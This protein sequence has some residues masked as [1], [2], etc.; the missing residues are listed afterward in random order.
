MTRPHRTWAALRASLALLLGAGVLLGT[1][2]CSSDATFVSGAGG[3]VVETTDPA[4]TTATSSAAGVPTQ[5]EGGELAP[6]D[7][8][9]EPADAGDAQATAAGGESAATATPEP[10][11]ST[12]GP[13][14]S[15]GGGIGEVVEEVAVVVNAPVA[16]DQVADFG[17]QV[18]ARLGAISPL[19]ATATLPGEIGGPALA[20]TV[21]IA[22]GR[23]EPI[24]LDAVTVS[25]IDGAGNA[26]SEISGEPASP[27]AGALQPG[28]QA[29]GVYVF[30]VPT[31]DQAN[32]SL[33]VNYSAG[34]PTVLFTGSVSGA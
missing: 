26:A 23:A 34:A 32:L 1:A 20:I 18:T 9:S 3:A 17:G 8:T 14:P 33:T 5:V 15:T 7:E 30:T 27:L 31:A 21:D 22:N 2:A 6:G 11:V 12:A 25:L 19:E 29:S 10:P 28:Q 24:G 13:A 16:L 4:T